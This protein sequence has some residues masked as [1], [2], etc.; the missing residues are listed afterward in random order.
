MAHVLYYV[1]DNL[2]EIPDDSDPG[3]YIPILV[4]RMK[5]ASIHQ[6]TLTP[7]SDAPM[8]GRVKIGY[9][10]IT[11]NTGQDG[12]E[13]VSDGYGSPLL[14]DMANGVQTIT[15]EAAIM[16]VAILVETVTAGND[17]RVGVAGW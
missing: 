1:S 12:I 3:F 16:G 4:E 2:N 5:E 10:A 14:V 8:T 7:D 11:N 6:I 15:F 9:R 13:W 17:I